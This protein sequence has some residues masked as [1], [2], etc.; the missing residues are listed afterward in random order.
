MRILT[1]FMAAWFFFIAPA[2]TNGA[3]GLSAETISVGGESRSYWLYT[4][5][6]M[7]KQKA[8]PLLFVLHGSGGTGED[9][10][11]V[12]QRGFERL[13]EKDKFTVVYPVAMERRWNEAG[14][15]VDDA[16]YLLAVAD[17]LAAQGLVDEK[18]VY[19]VG[20]SNG[21]MMAQ[22]MACEYADRV[23]GIASVAGSM[24]ESMAAVCKPSRAMP[25]MLVHGT[26]DPIIPWGG[27]A[28]AGFEEFGKV[29]SVMDTARFWAANNRCKGTALIVPEPDRD[30]TD[31]TRVRLEIF[32]DCGGKS[33]V[34]LVVAEGGGHTW[35]GGYQYLPERFIGKTSKD[36][37][38]N[39]LIW[40]FFK[41]YSSKSSNGG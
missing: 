39:S 38:A 14:G 24:T 21:G 34:S 22:R 20:I 5:M 12:T 8:A 41:K 37:D 26:E 4:P 40:N 23:A 33:A 6:G 9:M 19:F 11:D 32:A 17:R 1:V 2:I 25:A 35:P 29:I 7:E 16:G 3:A 31:G 10:R 13:A 28:V 30:T 15:T 27:G 18:K 36:I